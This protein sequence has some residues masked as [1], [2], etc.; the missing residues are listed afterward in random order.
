MRLVNVESHARRPLRSGFHLTAVAEDF[1]VATR[2]RSR[3]QLRFQDHYSWASSRSGL[4]ATLSFGP[5]GKGPKPL[6]RLHQITKHRDALPIGLR[7]Y[8]CGSPAQTRLVRQ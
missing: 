3:S 2:I 5:P 8:A 1:P 7:A 4:R 6:F